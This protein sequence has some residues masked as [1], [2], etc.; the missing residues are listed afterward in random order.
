MVVA[1]VEY[2]RKDD[3]ITSHSHLFHKWGYSEIEEFDPKSVAF[4]FLK[5]KPPVEDQFRSLKQSPATTRDKSAKKQLELAEWALSHGLVKDCGECLDAAAGL[6]ANDP[7]VKLYKQVKDALGKRLSQD[8]A[9][10]AWEGRTG[11][12]RVESDHYVVLFDSKHT[13]A[14]EAKF[15]LDHL[16]ESLKGIYYWFTL[17]RQALPTPERRMIALLVGKTDEFQKYADAF[18]DCPVVADSLFVRRDNLLIISAQRLDPAAESLSR[19]LAD[20]SLANFDLKKIMD[21]KNATLATRLPKGKTDEEWA[22]A[23][24]L[25]LVKKSVDEQS[26]QATASHQG[27]RQLFATI[28]LLPRTVHLP[29]W[30][31]FGLPSVF[32]VPGID[33]DLQIGAFWP[34]VGVPSW[35]HLTRYKMIEQDKGLDPAEIA[36]DRVVGDW[37]FREAR[38]KNDPEALARARA[39]AW[40]LSYYLVNRRIDGL[41]RYSQELALLPRDLELEENVHRDCFARAFGLTDPGEKAKFAKDWYAFNA[42]A[43]LPMPEV[44]KMARENLVA[45]EKAKEKSPLRP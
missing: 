29:E 19:M 15:R 42:V 16:E 37:Y 27:A 21:K 22:T 17:H 30:V 39:L 24:T 7:V 34:G 6:D 31:Q 8:D 18:A 13:T 35:T 38:L 23:S 14:E 12:K 9:A 26:E 44:L 28:G 2:S 10:K 33:P 4:A 3:A 41:Q 43:A 40:S 25:A 36:L 45:R 1:L 20:V 32:E 11:S 5:G